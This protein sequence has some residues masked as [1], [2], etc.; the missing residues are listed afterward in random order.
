MSEQVGQ[1]YKNSFE[2]SNSKKIGLFKKYF[3]DDC[4]YI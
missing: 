2:Q 1:L 4:I 3:F